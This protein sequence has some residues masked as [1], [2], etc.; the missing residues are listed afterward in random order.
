VVTRNI[1]FKRRILCV[2]PNVM[3]TRH[4]S[5]T[6]LLQI[7]LVLCGHHQG[8][9]FYIDLIILGSGVHSASNRNEHQ[10]QKNCV[11]GE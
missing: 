9:H 3:L 2:Q 1:V 4:F 5:V 8:I 10:K 11:S 6:T 7:V